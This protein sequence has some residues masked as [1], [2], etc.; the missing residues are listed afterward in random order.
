MIRRRST[1]YTII[2]LGL[3]LRVIATAVLVAYP[4]TSDS[5]SY[6]ETAIRLLSGEHFE[7]FW[8]PGLPYYLMVVYS[9]FDMS[10]WVDRGAMIVFYLLLALPLYWLTRDLFG[11]AAANL[12][13]LIVSVYPNY[14]FQSV[15]V[16]TQLPVA[17][18]LMIA[19]YAIYRLSDR[20]NAAKLVVIGLALATATLF[21]PGSILLLGFVPLY[22][23][24]P[25]RPV[26]MAVV[27]VLVASWVIGGHIAYVYS[28]N[29]NF[30]LINYANSYNLWLGN[31]E[32]TPLYRTWLFGTDRSARPHAM[33]VRNWEIETH[34]PHVQDKLYRQD[35]I[36]HILERPDLFVVRSFNRARAYWGFD[37]IAGTR[38]IVE[39]IVPTIVGVVVIAVDALF[40]L[41]V[42]IPALVLIINH[43]REGLPLLLIGGV[44]VVYAVP[45]VVSFAHP[46]YRVPVL[47]LMMVLSAGYWFLEDRPIVYPHITWVAL[48]VFVLIQFEWAAVMLSEFI[49]IV[50]V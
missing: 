9:I 10:A 2:S 21:R 32:F 20:G 42:M 29:Q 25:R 5:I 47:P 16:L 28:I 11:Y 34:L 37:T 33:D 1:I 12:A 38:L 8:P 46:T 22:I 15:T 44:A 23:V 19:V 39:D 7:P 3:F 40:Y 13:V 4:A 26:L 49:A 50:E 45:Y 30:M 24:Y 17:A 36:D 41:F 27:P 18:C 43:P 6:K 35:A 14:I 48:G 31:N